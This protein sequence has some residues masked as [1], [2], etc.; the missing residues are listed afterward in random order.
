MKSETE[1]LTPEVNWDGSDFNFSNLVY[2]LESSGSS[3]SI[4][5]Q[6]VVTVCHN[7]CIYNSNVA[8]G[9]GFVTATL[10]WNVITPS[11][12]D[13]YNLEARINGEVPPVWVGDGDSIS[14]TLIENS[15]SSGSFCNIEYVET[16]DPCEPYGGT[17]LYFYKK[18]SKGMQIFVNT[19][20]A[21]QQ[22][23]NKVKLKKLGEFKR[24]KLLK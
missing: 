3:G 2:A 22:H 19:K 20:K 12:F 13:P 9:A 7:C 8:V 24:V 21:I 1:F 23:V 16:I 17:P 4:S 11:E 18:T 15:G 14:V 10:T 5:G 6:V